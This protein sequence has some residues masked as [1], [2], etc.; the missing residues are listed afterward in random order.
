MIS[1]Y[2]AK[3]VMNLGQ[4][5]KKTWIDTSGQIIQY[6]LSQTIYEETR[7]ESV[8]VGGSTAG[9][10]IWYGIR[11]KKSM[12]NIE[13]GTRVSHCSLRKSFKKSDSLCSISYF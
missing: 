3:S 10:T 11:K 2:I 12:G 7:G 1:L 6:M 8:I 5:R 9:A 4:L 13:L